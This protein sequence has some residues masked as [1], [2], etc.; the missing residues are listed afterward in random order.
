[1]QYMTKDESKWKEVKG[2]DRMEQGQGECVWRD[3]GLL[4]PLISRWRVL[5]LTD[6]YAVTYFSSTIF[7]PKGMDTYR[8]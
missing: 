1:M 8:R 4:Y 2:V 5:A 6:T 3:S 7:T